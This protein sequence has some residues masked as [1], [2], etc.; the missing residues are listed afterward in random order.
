M[1]RG[2]RHTKATR[3]RIAEGKRRWWAQL[4]DA[5]RERI[6]RQTALNFWRLSKQRGD[7]TNVER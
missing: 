3:K 2:S 7:A 5:E 6:G 4:S 1:Q